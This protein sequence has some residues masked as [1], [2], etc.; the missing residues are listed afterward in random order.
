MT[1]IQGYDTYWEDDKGKVT[2]LVVNYTYYPPV[3]GERNEFGVPMEPN[4][5]AEINILNIRTAHG[6]DPLLVC[7][8]WNRDYAVSLIT[9]R[10]LEE[11]YEE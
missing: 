6:Q 1:N 3:Q 8:D 9:T 5:E 4:T 2:L 7:E 10:I 11:R